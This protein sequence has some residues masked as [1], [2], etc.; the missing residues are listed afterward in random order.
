MTDGLVVAVMF[1]SG[2]AGYAYQG[3]YEPSG[4]SGIITRVGA[5][6][7][8]PCGLVTKSHGRRII[9]IDDRPAAHVYN[10]WIGHVLDE[11]IAKGGNVLFDTTMFP[12]AIDVG[13][14]DGV[15]HYR[16][17][18]PESITADGALCTFAAVEERTRIHSM[19]GAK[20]R[21]IDRA[22]RVAREAS[23]LIPDGV[24]GVAGELVVYCAGCMAAVGD[25]MDNV[26]QEINKSLNGRPFLACFTFGEQGR[27][28]KRNLHGNLM[29]SAIAFG[30]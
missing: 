15:P 16:L 13:S 19:R 22:G 18:H 10:E 2:T 1:P 11:K 20:T 29:I 9:S 12:L 28:L 5:A 23:A 3:G 30:R 4:Q 14:L 8:P 27:L 25:Q 6:N 7:D 17:I 24:S 21:L 26:M